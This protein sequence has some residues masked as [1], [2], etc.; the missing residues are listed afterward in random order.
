V[1]AIGVDADQAYLG[2]QVL[3]SA[4]KKVDVAVYDTVK[5]AQDGSFK[6]GTN[7]TFDLTNN[8]A[9]IGKISSTGSKYQS[10]VEAVQKKV[11]DG[12][13][14]VPDTVK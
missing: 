5:A 2:P 8:G 13:V 1:Q 9:G 3:T 12:S 6:G 10:K 14:S 4:I 11:A 7:Q